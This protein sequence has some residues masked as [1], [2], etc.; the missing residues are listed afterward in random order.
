MHSPSSIL[1]LLDQRKCC[2]NSNRILYLGVY[3]STTN[4]LTGNL[5][6][7]MGWKINCF[8][9]YND[10][11]RFNRPSVNLNVQCMKE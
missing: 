11:G 5:Y 3:F 4:F 8:C 1:A 6:N 7:L 2:V 10:E 9:V